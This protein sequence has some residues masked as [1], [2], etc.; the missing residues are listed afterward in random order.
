MNAHERRRKRDIGVAFLAEVIADVL[1]EARADGSEGWLAPQQIRRKLGFGD[2]QFASGLC[3]GILN[4]MHQYGEV[5]YKPGDGEGV[6]D[7]R[8]LP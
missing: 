5:E 6:Y 4:Q 1:A 8:L 7:W 3:R 2:K